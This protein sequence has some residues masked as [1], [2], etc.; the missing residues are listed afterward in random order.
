[1]WIRTTVTDPTGRVVH[2]DDHPAFGD[3]D[4]NGTLADLKTLLGQMKRAYP[5]INFIEPESYAVT[6]EPYFG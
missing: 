2:I 5:D 3:Q 4:F 6:V 1:M